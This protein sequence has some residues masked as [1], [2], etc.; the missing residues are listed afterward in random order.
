MSTIL[1]SPVDEHGAS[2]GSRGRIGLFDPRD[3]LESPPTASAATSGR[4]RR[5][6]MEEPIVKN[7]SN[8]Q[9]ETE[10]NAGDAAW[11]AEVR[12]CAGSVFHSSAWGRYIAGARSNTKPRRFRLRN[13]SDTVGVAL[14]FVTCSRH[15]LLAALTNRLWFDALPAV[16]AALAAVFIEKIESQAMSLGCVEVS[17]GSYG[18][19]SGSQVLRSRRYTLTERLEFEIDL[20]VNEDALWRG[21][22]HGLRKN[23]K[24]SRRTGVVI[25]EPPLGEG[26]S[27]LR[28]LNEIA[29]E[30]IERRGVERDVAPAPVGVDSP[31]RELITAG[32]GRLIGA[33]VGSEWL[34]VNLFTCFNSQVYYVLSGHSPRAFEVQAPTHLLWESILRYRSEGVHL[35]NLGGCAASARQ[36]GS[37]EH[38][39]MGYKQA[40]G[41][42]CLECASGSRV[43]RPIRGAVANLLRRMASR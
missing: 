39:L 20:G 5:S 16:P 34:A 41:G 31:E 27:E 42:A 4:E 15:P 1:R 14:G 9:L 6:P 28:R 40:F 25:E 11:D 33:R 10:A 36:P 2:N 17:F 18:Y 8:Y 19:R 7:A 38:G 37:P 22:A 43:L 12:R 24:L 30:R 3:S 13:G 26:L 29:W 32:V 23:V 21:L 35:F